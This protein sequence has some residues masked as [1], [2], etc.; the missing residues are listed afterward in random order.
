[1]NRK[2]ICCF[3]VFVSAIV[4]T[5]APAKYNTLGGLGFTDSQNALY[6][7]LSDEAYRMLEQRTQQVTAIS[8]REGWLERQKFVREA[9]AKSIGEFPE[10]TP[11]NA[12][13]TKVIKRDGFRIEQVIFESQPRFYVTASLYVPDKAKKNHSTPALLFCSGHAVT[14]RLSPVY[15][16]QMQNFVQKGFIVL[17]FDPV[18]QGE[19]TQYLK[20]DGLTTSIP[21]PTIQHS[22]PGSQML[23]CG[24]SASRPMM[25]DGIRAIDYLLS[26]KE[27][28]PARIGVT[29]RSGGGTQ[30]AMIS[31]L[32]SRVAACSPEN[33]LTTYNRLFLTMGPQDAEQDIYHFIANGLDQT[34]LVMAMAPKPYRMITTT[35]DIFNVQGTKDIENEIKKAYQALGKADNFRRVEDYAPH[36]YTRKN[37][38]AN[39]AFYRRHFSLP[40]D[41]L[42]QDQ[43]LLPDS[44]M[45]ATPNGRVYSSLGGED[46]FTLNL[47]EADRLS[48][49]LD[50]R[51]KTG[52]NYYGHVAEEAKAL[53]GYREPKPARPMHLGSTREAAYVVERYA[54]QGEGGYWFPYL[55]YRPQSLT[56][57]FAVYLNA[58]GKGDSIAIH[59]AIEPMLRKGVSVLV[60]DLVGYGEMGPGAL[61]GDAW[62]GG[63]SHNLLYLSCLIGRSILAIRTADLVSLADMIRETEKVTRITGVAHG[64][65]ASILLHAAAFSKSLDRVV[66]TGNFCSYYSMASQRTYDTHA[67]MNIVPGALTA[68]DLPDLAASLAPR[69]LSAVALSGSTY[70]FSTIEQQEKEGRLVWEAYKEAGAADNLLIKERLEDC[71]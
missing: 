4:A 68:Y 45:Y 42:L 69:P 41:T 49:L 17:S 5:A 61:R 14:G 24:Y 66:L 23:L 54:T 40:G 52:R 31:A 29:G 63:V 60:P 53:A 27:V 28:D 67:A 1:M 50:A 51:R 44:E 8:T 16:K 55:I 2:I 70:R 64:E 32:D 57:E 38:E 19:R 7:Y 43:E 11:L 22:Y 47:K 35:N 18:G 59:D 37:N 20:A 71:F 65:T 21:G 39:Y 36:E 34:D 6:K 25:W 33:Y 3:L 10:R 56:G 13:V 26:R 62:I 9:L 46:L 48:R 15:Q 58:A 12:K 30:T